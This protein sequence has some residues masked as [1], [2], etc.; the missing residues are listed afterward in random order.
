MTQAAAG[1]RT[2]GTGMKEAATG[3]MA[4]LGDETGTTLIETAIACAILLVAMIGLLSMGAIATMHTENEGHLAARTTE[5]AQ[6]KLEQ[7]L[8]LAYADT[9]SNTVTFPAGTT[10]GTGLTVGG[11][12][13]TDAPFD[14]YVDWLSYDGHLLGGGT[15]A[16]DDWFY[17][18]VWRIAC[19]S[20]PCAAQTGIKE[21]TVVTRVRS[22]IGKVLI[23]KSTL[24]ALKS[25]EF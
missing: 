21:A 25:A 6:D 22:S 12:I 5:Y 18:R 1:T 8:V 7:L 24:V 19:V 20:S 23:P 15:T 13:D 9:T 11:G 16:P 17:E 2:V 3:A 10:G 4:R 14:G